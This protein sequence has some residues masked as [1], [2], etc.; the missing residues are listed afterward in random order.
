MRRL[1]SLFMTCC[2][3]VSIVCPT[4]SGREGENELAAQAL[5]DMSGHWAQSAVNHMSKLELMAG[6]EDGS[7]RPSRK[8][9]RAEFVA[10][11]YRVF[12]L[13]GQGSLDFE[14]VQEADWYYA[15]VMHANAS[16]IIQGID[17]THLSPEAPITRQEAAVMID[18][19][20]Q[21]STG[22]ESDS[23]LKRFQDHKS[24]SEYAKKALAFLVKEKKIK[25][26][27]GKLLPK[28]PITRAET[29]VL[30]AGMIEDV[31]RTP[32]VYDTAKVEGNLVVRASGITLKNTV[33]HGNLL[34]AEGIAEGDVTLEGVTVTG[35]IIIKG[36]GS[37][38]VIIRNSELE[39]VVVDKNGEPVRVVFMEGTSAND[40]MV[41]QRS[42]VE[43]TQDSSIGSLT[44][45]S[46]AHHT[47]IEFKGS[48]RQLAVDASGVIINGK[49]VV[50]G[51][52]SFIQEGG[53]PGTANPQQ[54]G[55]PI[56]E[57]PVPAT[58]IP[59]HMWEL[60]WQDEFNGPTI[61]TSKW[62]VMD[63]S[64]VYN[65]E[66]E[67][68]SP[69]NVSLVKEDQK[70]VLQIE[71]KK[72]A[73]GGQDYTSGKL[74]TKEKGDWTYGKV[75]VRAKLPVKQGMWPAI[76]MLPT[77]EAHYG[78][79]PASGEIDI[80]ELIGGEQ[81]KNRVYGTLHF[82]SKQ[83]DGT[84]G[85]DQNMY[86]L[87]EA[88]SFADDYHDFQVEWLPGVIR[89]YV[90]GQ[91]YHEVSDWRT[92]EPGQPEYYTYPAPFDRPFYLILNLAVGGDWPG[93]PSSDLV[94]DTM[95][96]DFVRVYSYKDID[97]W[98]EVSG[99]PPEPVQKRAPQ[100]DG[101]Q[102]YNNDFTGA[103][104]A[105]GTPD[106]WQFLLNVNGA[107]SVEV[108]EDAT[109]GKAVKATI[110]NSGEEIYSLQLTQ[111]PMY[112]RKD[113]QYK[114]TFDAKASANR[115]IMSKVN[116]F[117]KNWTNYS[118]EQTVNLTT[119]WQSYEYTFDMRSST[120]NN[121]RVEFNLGLNTESV[122]IAN[123]HLEEVGDA[124]TL[125]SLPVDRTALPDGN[126]IYNGTFD[127]GKDRLAFWSTT[128]AADAAAQISVNNFLKFP[129][130]ERQLVVNVTDAGSEPEAI[131]I[132]QPDL[133]LEANATYGLY[134]EAKA[135]APRSLDIDLVSANG[136]PVQFPQ[137]KTLQL[138][139][140]WRT[141]AK[142]IIVGED[143]AISE[144]E[145]RLLF[146][147]YSETVYVD[148]VRLVKRGAPI[149]IDGYA[150]APA[151]QAWEMQGL[152]FENSSEGGKNIAYM[153]EGDLL[154]FKISAERNAE[155]VLSAR[156][157][158]DASDSL[159]RFSVKD[160][161][162]TQIAQSEISLGETGGWQ[163]YKTIYFPLV[164]LEADQDYYVNFEGVDYNT[165]WMDISENKV[166][167]SRL[168]PVLSEWDMIPAENMETSRSVNGDLIIGVPDTTDKQWY[169]FL[170]Q[171]TGIQLV[172]GKS[173]RLEFDAYASVP[174]V[175]QAVVSENGG[176]FSKYINEEIELTQTKSHFTYTFA[177]GE[178]SDSAAVLAFGLGNP[179]SVEGAHTLSINQVLLFEV[180]PAAEQGGQPIN[181]NVIHNGDFSR[182]TEGWFTY[183]ADDP[184]QLTMAAT[185][186]KL[187][188]M[189]GSVGGNSWDRQVINE[190][191]TIQ[192][193]SRYTL[194]FKAKADVARK[195]GI[196]I[197]WVDVPANYAWH[198]YFEN[199]VDL[200]DEEQLFTFTFDAVDEGYTNARISFDMGNILG[201]NAGQTKMTISDVSLVNMGP[202]I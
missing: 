165:L 163:T 47:T 63:T 125:P 159:I 169:D 176:D 117:Q 22:T 120:D 88:Q 89:F 26:Y 146:G 196:G 137:G 107:G 187:E 186:G 127:Q 61:D 51:W 102:I 104:N 162:G 182:G 80:M 112:I 101:N 78:G 53:N 29:A 134:F 128:V 147:G 111:M 66:L 141:Y 23:E 99:N 140:E 90:D 34:L 108:L 166:R 68:Y 54:P 91:L 115:S 14:D 11:L 170:L 180:N 145:L 142:E 150:H 77:D 191:F 35:S 40:V 58:T 48:I 200:T 122:Y 139:N 118:G 2:L 184:N 151:S 161:A 197:G 71:A 123:V 74:I 96:V 181:V 179:V 168:A 8:I 87:A 76:W 126:L 27:N 157:A 83:P 174:K 201:G 198:G 149:R 69:N 144:F 73:Y 82:D 124:E 98:P 105:A 19:A 143:G 92:K 164:H 46:Q 10:V 36:G 31:I 190:G 60:D 72:E 17:K 32:I 93:V 41:L 45:G 97:N 20:F 160:G 158:S 79:W 85:H 119:E 25:G 56:G 171:Q 103:V 75:V 81:G 173:Y 42:H 189:I 132:A 3:I 199:Q 183:A 153:G 65:N 1:L 30:L 6:Y 195:L 130:M 59:D 4:I 167:N 116:Q 138:T 114:V 178:Q 110:T 33:I 62:T 131:I 175:I 156:V 55:T 9:S 154:Q 135:D 38:S 57:K 37:Q 70:S 136:N 44:V 193:G 50:A 121:A 94:S 15:A 13:T 202:I 192:K 148:N 185:N 194:T 52:K 86:T 16:G 95:K 109:K 172:A 106:S 129:I 67:Y 113:K 18:R 5:T 21:L 155:Y 12:G 7:F 28:S 188:A 43:L 39:R 133:E 152:Q 49:E 64:V 24:I 177:M 100:A 84:H